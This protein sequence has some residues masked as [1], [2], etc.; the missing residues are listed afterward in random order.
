MLGE[1]VVDYESRR[2]GT[3]RGVAQQESTMEPG[4]LVVKTSLFGRERLIPIESV[5]DVGDAVR[6]PFSRAAVLSAPVPATLFT[7]DS[8][9]QASLA[10]H[11]E[12]AA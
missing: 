8:A 9:E 6:V 3:V 7:V 1:P 10:R 5:E 12:L 2:V 4:W 11:Y